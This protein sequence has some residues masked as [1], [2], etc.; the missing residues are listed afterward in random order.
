MS[1]HI[2]HEPQ[3]MGIAA[4]E[5]IFHM[6]G[7]KSSLSKFERGRTL[8]IIDGEQRSN[9]LWVKAW[10]SSIAPC[11]ISLSINMG[12]HVILLGCIIWCKLASC[13]VVG[14]YLSVRGVLASSNEFV[15]ILLI[16]YWLVP[17]SSIT[18]ECTTI[19]VKRISFTLVPPCRCSHSF[20]NE[21]LCP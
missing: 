6:F 19:V 9:I 2:R 16:S 18:K 14:F 3:A 10:Q 4:C 15:H 7:L 11:L 20:M 1:L 8:W 21:N 13:H 17:Y 5:H 12:Q